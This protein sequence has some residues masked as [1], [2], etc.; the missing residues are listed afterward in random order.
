MR[1]S[2]RRHDVGGPVSNPVHDSNVMSA[3]RHRTKYVINVMTD[4]DTESTRQR[5]QNKLG[6]L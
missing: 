6:R 1:T 5:N 3:G 4:V 2:S